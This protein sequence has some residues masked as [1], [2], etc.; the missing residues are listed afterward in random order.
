MECPDGRCPKLKIYISE[1]ILD[2]CEYIPVAHVTM[3]CMV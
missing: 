3:H 2:G 1:L